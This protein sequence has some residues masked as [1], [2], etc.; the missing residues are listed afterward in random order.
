MTLEN[1]NWIQV[2]PIPDQYQLIVNQFLENK[3]ILKLDKESSEA[4]EG[5][6]GNFYYYKFE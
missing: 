2:E 5:S 3:E 1:E 6:E 4:S